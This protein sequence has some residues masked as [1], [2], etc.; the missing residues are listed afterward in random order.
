MLKTGQFVVSLF[1]RKP[2]PCRATV[3]RRIC[4]PFSDC[5][6]T[7]G[8]LSLYKT[9]EV[10]FIKNSNQLR[11]KLFPSG[12]LSPRAYFVQKGRNSS[13]IKQLQR[14]RPTR[15]IYS[16]DSVDCRSNRECGSF[17]AIRVR[18]CINVRVVY[19]YQNNQ[20]E[21]FWTSLSTHLEICI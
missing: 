4:L 11:M 10:S 19:T 1:M 14:R 6:Y 20:S 18:H 17:R 2:S 7:N 13:Q 21:E 9:A 5:T 8:N 15:I 16:I 3:D 12:S